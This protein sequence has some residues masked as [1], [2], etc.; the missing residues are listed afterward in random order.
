[1]G[2]STFRFCEELWP[3]QNYYKNTYIALYGATSR[4]VLKMVSLTLTCML[5]SNLWCIKSQRSGQFYHIVLSREAYQL[6][7]VC[8]ASVQVEISVPEMNGDV[9]VTF[10]QH[11]LSTLHS[12]HLKVF[13]R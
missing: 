10:K 9:K 6:S 1:M 7:R 12:N 11:S 5:S 3:K 8:V 2:F 13:C 4:H